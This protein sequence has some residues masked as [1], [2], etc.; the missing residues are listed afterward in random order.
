MNGEN[1]VGSDPTN[2]RR[3]EA[4]VSQRMRRTN[5]SDI[6]KGEALIS[7]ALLSEAKE[8]KSLGWWMDSGASD[9]MSYMREWFIEYVRFEQPFPVRIGNGKKFFAY[10][11]G[12]INILSLVNGEWCEKHLENVLYV[13]DM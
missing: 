2:L 1:N 12:C 13:P 8:F 11:K 4:Y 5:H 7:I 3:G 6:R 10:G 9:H